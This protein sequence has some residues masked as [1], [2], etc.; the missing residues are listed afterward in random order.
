ME[1]FALIFTHWFADF[2][3]QTDEMAKNKSTSWKW[4]LTHIGVYSLPFLILFGPEYALVNALAHMGVDYV[5][6]RITSKLYEAKDIH[7]FFVVVGFDQAV[8]LA[9]LIATIPLMGGGLLV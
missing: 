7:N 3:I 2:V 6:S 8:H 1:I 9:I 5:T 4:L